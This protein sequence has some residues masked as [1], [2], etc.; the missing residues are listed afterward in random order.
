MR[1]APFMLLFVFLCGCAS[2]PKQMTGQFDAQRGDCIV[3]KKDGSLY[4]SPLSK[5]RD[6]LSFVGIAAPDKHD[7][8]L[9]RLLRPSASLFR[10]PSVRFSSDY[11]RATVDWDFY[12]HVGEAVARRST[13]FERVSAK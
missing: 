4:W 13:E 10:N 12:Q 8:Q 9:V 7:A 1:I 11:S 5:T 3:I 2:F 6:R